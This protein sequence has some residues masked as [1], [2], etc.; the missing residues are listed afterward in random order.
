MQRSG[1]ICNA[2]NSDKL[3]FNHFNVVGKNDCFQ[4]MKTAKNPGKPCRAGVTT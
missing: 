3:R 2:C 1:A 4:K